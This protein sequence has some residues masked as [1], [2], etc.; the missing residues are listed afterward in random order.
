M[1]APV[2]SSTSTSRSAIC[3]ASVLFCGRLPLKPLRR[4]LPLVCRVELLTS[5]SIAAIAAIAKAPQALRKGRHGP[6]RF[7][8]ISLS[9][10]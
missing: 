2:L 3:S 7:P 6:H 4:A 5:P 8:S 10:A 1:T 9:K